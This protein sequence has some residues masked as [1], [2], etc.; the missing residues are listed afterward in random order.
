MRNERVQSAEPAQ[1][2]QETSDTLGGGG[3]GCSEN[4]MQD[5]MQ[6]VWKSNARSSA[7]HKFLMASTEAQAGGETATLSRLCSD[8]PR[9]HPGPGP[10]D[11]RCL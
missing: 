7:A 8:A 1:Q 11:R 2:R 10:L 5:L 9:P 4:M 6:G 3:A